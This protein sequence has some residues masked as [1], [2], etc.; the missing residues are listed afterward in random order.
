MSHTLVDCVNLLTYSMEQYPSREA[1]SSSNLLLL[2]T[3]QPS[4]NFRFFF[5]G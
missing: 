4:Q 3:F 1:T 5:I 2:H